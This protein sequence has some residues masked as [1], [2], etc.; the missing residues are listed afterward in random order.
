[1]FVPPERSGTLRRLARGIPFRRRAF[2]VQEGIPEVVLC[3]GP[4][5]G[6]TFAGALFERGFVG[7]HGHSQSL[8]VIL[9]PSQGHKRASEAALG[10]SPIERYSFSGSFLERGTEGRQCF[11]HESCVYLHLANRCQGNAEVVLSLG[12]MERHAPSGAYLEHRTVGVDGVLNLLC[13]ASSSPQ[14]QKSVR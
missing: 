14:H 8:D 12:P 5:E 6:R 3:F 4:L 10:L 2:P 1:M 13:V 7:Y 11:G 9:L